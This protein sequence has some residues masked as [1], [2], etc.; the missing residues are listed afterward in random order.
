MRQ[1]GVFQI[2]R[3]DLTGERVKGDIEVDPEST[4]KYVIS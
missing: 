3:D 1:H 4:S 2:E